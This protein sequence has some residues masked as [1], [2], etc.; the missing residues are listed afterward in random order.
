M[1]V[2]T[3]FNS[4]TFDHIW[5]LDPVW[6]EVIRAVLVEEETEQGICLSYFLLDSRRVGIRDPTDQPTLQCYQVSFWGGSRQDAC[7]VLGNPRRSV[8]ADI[9]CGLVSPSLFVA[10]PS[11]GCS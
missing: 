3:N 9:L 7:F 6:I 5:S 1:G 11:N 10:F 4:V 8:L 2:A